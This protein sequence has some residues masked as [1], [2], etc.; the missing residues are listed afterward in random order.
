MR[1]W[2]I[3]VV[4]AGCYS[5]PEPDCGF[6]CG[7]GG[8]CPADYTCASDHQC[9][10]NGAAASLTP[11]AGAALAADA[12]ASL[13]AEDSGALDAGSDTP[14]EAGSIDGCSEDTGSSDDDGGSE[15]DGISELGG[16]GREET[17]LSWMVP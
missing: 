7:P 2:I 8:A 6:V 14:D 17:S 3:F 10:R 12:E 11:D 5:P 15:L 4:L 9:H 1:A 16:G 13:A